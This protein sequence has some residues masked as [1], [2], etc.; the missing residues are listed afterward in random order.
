MSAAYPDFDG[1]QK[2]AEIGVEPF[3]PDSR[4]DGGEYRKA[5]SLCDG[6]DWIEP[7]RE[8]SLH[9]MVAGVWGGTNPVDRR[10]IRRERGI[11][12]QPISTPDWVLHGGTKR[13]AA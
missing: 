2:C 6:C 12:A 8:Y 4:P 1:T 9:W 3:F 5:R 11:V 7:C 10:R 13:G